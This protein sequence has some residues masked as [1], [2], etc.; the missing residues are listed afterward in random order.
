MKIFTKKYL[1][2][3]YLFLRHYNFD[4][5]IILCRCVDVI[6]QVLLSRQNIKE[7]LWSRI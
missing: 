2:Y 5:A 7:C 1:I 6:L 4:I 3:V